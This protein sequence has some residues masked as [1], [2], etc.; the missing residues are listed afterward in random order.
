MQATKFRMRFTAPLHIAARGVGYEQVNWVIHSDTL[1]S[2]II[3]VWSR[4]DPEGA[5]R[6]A[7]SKSPPFLLSSAFPYQDVLEFYPKP[8]IRSRLDIEPDDGKKFARVQFI[9]VPIFREILSGQQIRF[10][11]KSTRQRGRFWTVESAPTYQDTIVFEMEVPRVV[12]DRVTN[13]GMNY[14]V[15][16]LHFAEG[17]GLFFWVLFNEPAKRERFI[18]VLR[19][20]GDEGLGLDRTSGKGFFEVKDDD[21][22]DDTLPGPEHTGRFL[23]LSLYCPKK[24]EIT[25]ATLQQSGYELA[26]RGGYMSGFSY[27][28]QTLTM[29][30]EGSVF[31]G[32]PLDSYGTKREVLD[33]DFAKSTVHHPIYRYGYAFPIGFY[34]EE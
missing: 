28:R 31:T 9:E 7:Q 21:I 23:I 2:S 11:P 6:I 16:E 8:L 12:I 13:Q 17:A 14:Y 25:Q 5:E 1:Y 27:R 26:K 33:K 15:S 19:L 18:Q 32:S 29:F 30:T 34:D 10:D 20:L 3:T 24:E 4:I 22:I